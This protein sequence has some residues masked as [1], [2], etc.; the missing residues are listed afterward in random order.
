MDIFTLNL[1]APYLSYA[2]A[3]IEQS[4]LQTIHA[5]TFLESTPQTIKLHHVCGFLRCVSE[6]FPTKMQIS[7][8]SSINE[9]FFPQAI[10]WLG[11]Q[12]SNERK[13]SNQNEKRMGL[14]W[15]YTIFCL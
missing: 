8:C 4:L 15:D 10:L 1:D 3:K 2:Q 7:E 5:N 11:K 9:H 13:M 12:K 14:I 6:P